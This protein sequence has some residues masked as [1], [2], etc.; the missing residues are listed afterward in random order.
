MFNNEW[1][2]SQATSASFQ[3]ILGTNVTYNWVP[4]VSYDSVKGYPAIVA[5]WHWGYKYGQG[6]GNLPVLLSSKPTIMTSW[7]IAHVSSTNEELNT[8]WDIWLGGSG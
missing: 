7:S 4:N 1:G 3:C 2:A 8:S 5:G 6:V